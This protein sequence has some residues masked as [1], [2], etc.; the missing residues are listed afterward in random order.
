MRRI[1]RRFVDAVADGSENWVVF[2]EDMCL[3]EPG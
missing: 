3:K 1:S 2:L